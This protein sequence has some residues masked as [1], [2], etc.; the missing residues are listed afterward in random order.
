[1]K[2]QGAAPWTDRTVQSEA[3]LTSE[4]VSALEPQGH[5]PVITAALGDMQCVLASR[6]LSFET[7]GRG[8]ILRQPSADGLWH[9]L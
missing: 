8:Q 1:M 5:N 3:V 4:A 2:R 9:S 7:R 6:R